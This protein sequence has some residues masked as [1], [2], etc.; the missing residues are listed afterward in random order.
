MSTPPPKQPGNLPS[1]NPN[2][3]NPNRPFKPNTQPY[4]SKNED[5]EDE[6][7]AAL[8]ENYSDTDNLQ[9]PTEEIVSPRDAIK[10]G[11]PIGDIN[12]VGIEVILKTFADDRLLSLCTPV[13]YG[14]SRVLSYHRKVLQLPDT[15]YHLVT[16][17]LKAKSKVLNVVN[18]WNEEV[19]IT[20]GRP[21]P[22]AGQ[23]ALRA[24]DAA[25]YD[26]QQGRLHAIVTAPVNKNVIHDSKTPFYGH[27]EYLAQKANT[28]HSLMLLVN[29]QMRMAIVTN[30]LPVSKIAGKITEDLIYNKLVILNDSL[31]R[32]FGFN[33]PRIAVLGLNPHASDEGLIGN[34]EA[35]MITPAINRALQHNEFI[36]GP[37]AADSFFGSGLYKK[38]DAVLAM[39]HD[40]GLIPFKTLGFGEGVNFTAGL[41]F[42]RTSPDHGTAYDIAG[43][44][45]ANESSF[46]KAVF[47]AIDIYYNRL[48]YKDM[49]ANPLQRASSALIAQFADETIAPDDE[50]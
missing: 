16:D 8:S 46:R 21:N 34:E 18:C 17:A 41:P 48:N 40:Q 1:K 44:N 5:E 25:I 23:F 38:F 13:I 37:Y 33:R 32:D 10:I 24:L 49:Y 43:R 20:I 28:P 9:E 39:Y 6:D 47:Q 3:T 14:S 30:H 26:M 4:S 12:G 36:F 45:L 11:I 19:Q 7:A 42:V 22:A 2:S 15:P 50:N 31:C 27:T 29:D 35:T